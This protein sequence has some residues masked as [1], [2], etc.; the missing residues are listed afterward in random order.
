MK[1]TYGAVVQD[2]SGRFG[3]TVHSSWKGVSLVR[4]FR[5]PANPN[6]VDQQEVRDIFSNLGRVWVGQTAQVRLAWETFAVGKQFIGR[7][8]W[9]ARNVQPLQ[10]QVNMNNLVMTPGDASTLPPIGMT[11]TPGVGTVTVAIT[12]PTPPTGW[13]IQA[14]VAARLRDDDPTIIQ[15]YSDWAWQEGE[16]AAAPYSIVI[17]PGNT[18]IGQFAGF[19]R[20]TAPDGSTRYSSALR[21]QAS[22]V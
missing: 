18:E 14:A 2:A 17:T 15:P 4:R 7:N 19:L 10:A 16:D 3:G 6:T 9:I 20:W 8:I 12:A 11:L 5:A 13:T 22:A 21:G 1:I